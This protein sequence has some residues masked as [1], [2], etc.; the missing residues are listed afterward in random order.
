MEAI[1]CR[2][3]VNGGIAHGSGH[4]VSGQVTH[5]NIPAISRRM[6]LDLALDPLA[7]LALGE[8]QI[9]IQLEAEPEAGRE[10]N[11]EC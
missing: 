8:H 11:V 9:V 1:A 6:W 10:R 3:V 5:F 4:I 7:I 2:P